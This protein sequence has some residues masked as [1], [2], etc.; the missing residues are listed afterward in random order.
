MGLQVHVDLLTIH[1]ATAAYKI[2]E[3]QIRSTGSTLALT[4]VDGSKEKGR[5]S[6]KVNPNKNKGHQGRVPHRGHLCVNKCLRSWRVHMDIP[7]GDRAFFSMPRVISSRP[8]S[9]RVP[10]AF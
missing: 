2:N 6:I 3:C 5:S 9:V 8:H 10:S 1:G 7:R 4:K